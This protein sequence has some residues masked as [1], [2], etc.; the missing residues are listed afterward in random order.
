MNFVVFALESQI[1]F[2]YE[3][4]STQEIKWNLENIVEKTS[5]ENLK[6]KASLSLKTKTKRHS[7]NTSTRMRNKFMTRRCCWV[8]WI[9]IFINNELMTQLSFVPWI[10]HTRVHNRMPE[11]MMINDSTTIRVIP[12]VWLVLFNPDFQWFFRLSN[13]WKVRVNAGIL[14]TP[15]DVVKYETTFTIPQIP[16]NFLK[17]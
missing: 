6:S 8:G 4:Q 16:L 13:V 1:N 10:Y 12:A 7:R 14:Y 15:T 3:M 11:L 2:D 9:I 17:R 5:D